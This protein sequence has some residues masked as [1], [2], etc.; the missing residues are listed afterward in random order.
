MSREPVAGQELSL[1]H[2]SAAAAG[3]SV[4]SAIVVNP[5]DVA[6]VGAK[7]TTVRR[8]LLLLQAR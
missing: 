5:L 1:F 8:S 3:A 6:K 4:V 7:Q 2:R